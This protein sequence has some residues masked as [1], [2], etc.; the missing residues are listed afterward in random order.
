MKNLRIIQ[1]SQ[2]SL[3]FMGYLGG[4]GLLLILGCHDMDSEP[5]AI[6]EGQCYEGEI[7]GIYCPSYALVQVAN[8]KIGRKWVDKRGEIHRDYDNVIV[9]LNFPY[10]LS[11]SKRETVFFTVDLEKKNDINSCVEQIPCPVLFS[12]E[13][14]IQVGLCVKS[15]SVINCNEL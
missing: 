11:E 13:S 6:I 15:L 12:L 1:L 9:I 14:E 7:L 4:L 2:F 8:S 3:K 10:T 5:E